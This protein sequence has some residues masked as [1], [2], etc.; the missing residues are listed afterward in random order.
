M[1][2]NEAIPDVFR[3]T[4]EYKATFLYSYDGLIESRNLVWLQWGFD[5]IISIFDR[6][7]TRTNIEKTV[8]MCASLG[9]SPEDAL[10]QHMGFGRPS[11][12]TFNM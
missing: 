8:M 9:P 4:V 5:L 6:V 2:E 10:M 12:E 7:G 11:R 3:Y 1:A